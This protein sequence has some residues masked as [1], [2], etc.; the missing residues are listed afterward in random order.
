MLKILNLIIIA[1]TVCFALFAFMAS[2]IAQQ[3]AK[4]SV[5]QPFEVI[6]FVEQAKD[7]I[8]KVR[9]TLKPPPVVKSFDLQ[10]TVVDILNTES[11][12]V[13]VNMPTPDMGKGTLSTMGKSS[14]N[15]G[16]ARPIVRVSPK[17]PIAAQR[18]GKE[19]WVQLRFSIMKNGAVSDVQVV[20][21]EPERMFNKEAIRALKKWKYKAKIK[22]GKAIKQ[23]NMSVL[24]EFTMDQELG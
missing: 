1:G 8:V 4:P 23:E 9:E 12:T 16:E 18:D 3:A 15:N 11:V 19:G 14:I 17:Y 24:L 20:A 5:A 10:K 13:A 2:L 6:E 7:S 21:A 22:D